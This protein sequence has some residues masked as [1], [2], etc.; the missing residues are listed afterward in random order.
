[1]ASGRRF[2]TSGVI[3]SR[4]VGVEA[5]VVP[6]RSLN[7]VQLADDTGPGSRGSGPAEGGT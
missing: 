5:G 2:V 7:V 4:T 1:M 6:T 3:S